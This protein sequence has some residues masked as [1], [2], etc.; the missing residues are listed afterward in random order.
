MNKLVIALGLTSLLSVNAIAAYL[1][2]SAQGANVYIISPAD[3]ETVSETFT[4]KFGLNGMGVAPAGTVRINTG[5]HHLLIDGLELPPLDQPMNKEIK[6]FGGGQTETTLT[7]AP[8]AH[9]LQLILG[10]K[11]HIPHNLPVIS[12][13]IT[14]IVK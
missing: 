1:T 3:G 4:V 5:H 10:D 2:P 8:G 6:H 13:K 12:E 11:A 14:I 7:L 9:T